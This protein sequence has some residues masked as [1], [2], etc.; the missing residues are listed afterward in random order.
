MAD[1]KINAQVSEAV[2]DEVRGLAEEHDTY[3]QDVVA[4]AIKLGLHQMRTM[5][6]KALRRR[7]AAKRKT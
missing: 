4:V 1:V 6:R 7:I 5:D 3:V 2:R